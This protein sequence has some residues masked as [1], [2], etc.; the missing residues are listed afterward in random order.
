MRG[1]KQCVMEHTELDGVQAAAGSLHQN[2]KH[3]HWPQRVRIEQLFD[4]RADQ[5]VQSET[6]TEHIVH[7]W[8]FAFTSRPVCWHAACWHAAA[9]VALHACPQICAPSDLCCA[10]VQRRLTVIPMH[11]VAL[12][13]RCLDAVSS[14][15]PA[16]KASHVSALA[17]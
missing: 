9:E 2:Q 1:R 3:F 16:E 5:S 6:R 13:G 4:S 12:S 10:T 11:H 7:P 15:V 14:S 8:S 17:M